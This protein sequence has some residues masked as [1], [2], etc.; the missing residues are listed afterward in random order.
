MMR[1]WLSKI[2]IKLS[3]NMRYPYLKIAMFIL[4]ETSPCI[5]LCI[6]SVTPHNSAV[7]QHR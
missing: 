7:F 4:E 3:N 2:R 5:L 6:H 1:I